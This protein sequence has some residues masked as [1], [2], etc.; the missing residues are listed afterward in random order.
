MLAINEDLAKDKDKI[1]NTE[2]VKMMLGEHPDWVENAGIA[3]DAQSTL[4]ASTYL[5][6]NFPPNRD[7]KTYVDDVGSLV[8]TYDIRSSSGRGEPFCQVRLT[9]AA[10]IQVPTS[11]NG[12][13]K[14][15]LRDTVVRCL[16][17]DLR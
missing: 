3:Y 1:K 14:L 10:G 5:E 12:N 6:F 16:S 9:E 4:F 11:I 8:Y 17:P 7:G 13:A 15:M 2:V